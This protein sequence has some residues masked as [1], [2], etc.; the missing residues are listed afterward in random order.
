ML[1]YLRP[2]G[3]VGTRIELGAG[4]AFGVRMRVDGWLCGRLRAAVEWSTPI[5][6]EF[7]AAAS[8]AKDELATT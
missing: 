2:L 8:V 3:D 1:S 7:G 5:A 4:E 6:D